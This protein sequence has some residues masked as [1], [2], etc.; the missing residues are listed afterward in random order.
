[1]KPESRGM[2]RR[3]FQRVWG[4]LLTSCT[5][6]TCHVCTSRIFGPKLQYFLS[7]KYT[8]I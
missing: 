6:N 8:E 2:R 4:R 1:M 7:F 5:G 3:M